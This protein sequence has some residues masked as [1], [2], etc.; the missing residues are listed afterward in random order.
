MTHGSLQQLLEMIHQARAASGFHQPFQ[1]GGPLQPGPVPGNVSLPTFG[2]SPGGQQFGPAAQA[3]KAG[4]PAQAAQLWEQHHPGAMH[5]GQIPG[6]VEQQLVS[7]L[8]QGDGG[9]PPGFHPNPM[10]PS[11]GGLQPHEVGA[12]GGLPVPIPNPNRIPP[13]VA[14]GFK[15]PIPGQPQAPL[16]PPR[17]HPHAL[18][19]PG[20]QPGGPIQPYIHPAQAAAARALVGY[21]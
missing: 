16:P 1:P 2:G 19:P 4:D 10:Q 3:L 6:W 21:S 14:N 12:G 15:G 9:L 8:H 18:V 11:P 5:S 20:F 7:E 13:D 17:S